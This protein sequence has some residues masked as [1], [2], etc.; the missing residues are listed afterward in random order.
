MCFLFLLL[1]CE[2]CF[3]AYSVAFTRGVCHVCGLATLP[4]QASFEH[5]VHRLPA[6]CLCKIYWEF[7]LH[8][9]CMYMIMLSLQSFE[10]IYVLGISV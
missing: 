6:V 1:V 3:S 8:A 9:R 10:Q 7:V 2:F 5:L 4:S